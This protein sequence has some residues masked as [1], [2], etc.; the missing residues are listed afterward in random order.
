MIGHAAYH[1]LRQNV[2]FG[3][4]E[5]DISTFNGFGQCVDIGTV[6][7]KELFL[8]VQVCAFLGDYSLAVNHDDIFQAGSQRNIQFGTGNCGC[9]G[10]VDHDLNI[11]NLLACHFKR[12]QKSGT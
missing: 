8:F 11:F 5:E 6:G 4:S 12:I 2:S 1:V 9:S 10:T 7:S 3:Q